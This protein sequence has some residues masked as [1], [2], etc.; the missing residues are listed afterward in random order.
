MDFLSTLMDFISTLKT[1]NFEKKERN[2]GNLFG[3]DINNRKL[4]G[5]E[6]R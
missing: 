3:K 5:N 4:A 1:V 2:Y 6:N